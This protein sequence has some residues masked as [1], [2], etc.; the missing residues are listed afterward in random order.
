M[1]LIDRYL[2][3]V[4]VALPKSQRDDIVK[5]LSDS[6]LSQVEEREASLGRPLTEDEV[7]E[8]LL[9]MGKPAVLASRYRDQMGLIGPTVLP[10]YWKVLQAAL[11]I[12]LLVQVFASIVTV[13][14]GHSFAASIEPLF[15]YPGIALTVF[16][17]VTISF[18][19]LHFFGAKL[20]VSEKWDP[21]KLPA[22]VKGERRKSRTEAITSLVVGALAS[23][24][25]LYGL[26][27]TFWVFGPGVFFMTFGPVW[28]RL[29]PI[30]VLLAVAEVLRHTLQIVKP[31]A[32][33][34]HKAVDLAIRAVSLGVLMFLLRAKEIFVAADPGNPQ[35]QSALTALSHALRLGL[36]IAAAIVI[37]KLAIDLW[38]L[39]TARPEQVHHAALGS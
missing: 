15:R 9:K 17:W 20:Q 2:Q 26:R 18:A 38:K 3:A 8:L 34:V 28:M 13:A 32:T 14:S 7:A 12:A 11:G 37:V 5:E 29:Y 35:M 36:A 23:V 6:I 1:D 24:W 21:R 31:H 22:V 27:H 30:F 25:W 33:R 39:V 19:A 16:A 4:R 10:I